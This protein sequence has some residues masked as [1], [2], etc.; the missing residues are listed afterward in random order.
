MFVIITTCLNVIFCISHI[1]MIAFPI[2]IIH[3]GIFF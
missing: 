1:M 3:K 2:T